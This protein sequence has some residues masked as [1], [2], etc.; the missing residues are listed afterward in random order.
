MAP[1]I[2]RHRLRIALGWLVMIIIGFGAAATLQ[3]R[4]VASS[5]LEGSESAA[6]EDALVEH[7]GSP[8]AHSLVLVA[9]GLPGVPVD[10][11]QRISEAVAGVPGVLSV[12]SP[13]TSG[14]TLLAGAERGSAVFITG[15]DIQSV[16]VDSLIPA[17][18]T[19]TAG[20]AAAMRGDAPHVSL[21]WTGTAALAFDLRSTSK[22][23]SRRAELRALPVVLVLLFIAF[24]S[25]AA[26]FI[27]V[28]LGLLTIGVALGMA[29]LLDVAGRP[30]IL[31]G[32]V[33]SILGLA[34][35][36]DYS[37]LTVTRFREVLAGG[38]DARTA[39]IVTI[40]TAGHT[41]VISG[42][43]VALG[44]AGLL[45]VPV[46]E[47]R[48]VGLGGLI[49]AAVA[50][51]LA[52]TLLP[53]ALSWLGQ[54]IDAGTRGHR[55]SAGPGPAWYALGRTVTNHPVR[56]LLIAGLPLLLLSLP[57]F[58]LDSSA[59]RSDWLPAH[60]ESAA[61]LT[62]LDHMNRGSIAYTLPVVVAFSGRAFA[63][64]AEQWD[65]IDRIGTE[66]G[67]DARVAEV[68][69]LPAVAARSG[70]PL[71]LALRLVPEDVLRHF[72]APD[73]GMARIDVIPRANVAPA[74]LAGLVRSLRSVDLN[75]AAGRPGFTANVGGV[76]AYQVDYE[77]AVRRA[78]P[79][80]AASVLG[81]ILL[82]LAIGFRSILIPLKAT[83]LNLL[84]VGAAF[85]A[86]VLVFQDG[87]GTA[88]LGLDAPLS[89]VF[90]A[91]PILAFC[92]VFGLSMDYEVFLLGRIAEVRRT[93]AGGSEQDAIV[94]GV[95]R[96]GRVIT[97]AAALMAAIFIA[98]A[99][100]AYLPSRLLGF[101]LAVAVIAD[102]T[103]VRL[104]VGPALLQL[105]GRWNWWPGSSA[106]R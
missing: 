39:A 74:E 25:I 17:L 29:L 95:A 80:V 73:V 90:P 12:L 67:R 40:R 69:S 92:I 101:C 79:L 81:G 65:A 49:V 13:A 55:P 85:G 10:A 96:T 54:R 5:R 60:M 31:L 36:V 26:A 99:A 77:D 71:D 84:T 6:V 61:A 42:S 103:L 88:L 94:E 30:S 19:V 98:F 104:A 64:D 70:L 16:P 43:T 86:L 4:M 47:I 75:A 53:A 32:S 38:A 37:L 41:I 97:F 91:V 46:D 8:T 35:G 45:L 3:D 63:S 76:P 15:L 68:R 58:R 82:V 23:E 51:A 9:R 93:Q 27:P 33:V 44:F 66:F 106:W 24:R 57:A 52:T 48:S 28:V 56:T 102:V 100:G 22:S 62:D 11:V 21:R 87:Y 78:F 50:V 20:V 2:I 1:W 7:F 34:L 83:I 72:T 89:G 14:D 59:P 18:R 105:A